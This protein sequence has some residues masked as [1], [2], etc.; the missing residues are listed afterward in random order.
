MT[1]PVYIALC[2]PSDPSPVPQ[3]MYVHLLLAKCLHRTRRETSAL[4]WLHQTKEYLQDIK[5]LL[6]TALL[7]L[8]VQD[9]ISHFLPVCLYKLH[10]VSCLSFFTPF[11]FLLY[12]NK[13]M[14]LIVV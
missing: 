9:I 14:A 4:V 2:A 12:C 8:L 7:W 3:T 5:Y 11:L 13:Y 10:F 6:V 1:F